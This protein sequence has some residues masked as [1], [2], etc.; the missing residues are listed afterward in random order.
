MKPLRILFPLLAIFVPP[1][2]L[3]QQSGSEV[4]EFPTVLTASRLRQPANEAPASVTVIDRE[5]IR[6][7]GARQ[8]VDLFRFV[9]GMV[10]GQRE[11]HVPTL[12]FHGFSESYFRQLQVLVDG[13]SIYS[14]L[15]G[16][17]DWGEL[18]FS[19]ED[20]ERIEIV[21]GPN[22]AAYG[23]NAFA[24]VINI[25]TRDPATEPRAAVSV[26]SGGNG[27]GDLSIRIARTGEGWRYRLSAGSR[28]DRG[29]DKLPDTTRSDF[30]NLRSHFTL[31]STDELGVNLSYVGGNTDNGKYSNNAADTNA[32]RVSHYESKSSQLRWTRA[33]GPDEEMW[34]Q[35]HHAE[36]THHEVLPYTLNLGGPL[37]FDYPISF[38]YD[39][40][41]T[42]L[43]GQQTL[44]FSERLR[45]VW[46]VQWRQDGARSKTYFHSDSWQ[47]SSLLRLFGTLE[48]RPAEKWIAH[49]GAMA[50]RNDISG[51][52][53][54]PR[55]ALVHQ[56]TPQHALRAS[57]AS[58]RRT[59]T[60]FEAYAN[61]GFDSPSGLILFL[62]L[63]LRSRPLHQSILT[64]A[65]PQ[66]ERMLSRELAYLGEFPRWRMNVDLRLF[67]DQAKDMIS[68]YSYPY[69]TVLGGLAGNTLGFRNEPK[70]NVR[71][72]AFDLRWRPWSG[73]FVAFS[74]S[75]TIVDSTN[76]FLAR[77]APVHQ[78]SLLFQQ[79][80]PFTTEFGLNY[81]RVGSMTWIGAGK[82]ETMPAYDRVDARIAKRFTWGGQKVEVAWVSR[83]VFN[84]A[85]PQFQQAYIDKRQSWLSFRLEYQ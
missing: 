77:S 43:E 19:L 44:R 30:V 57:I 58:A 4:D 56:V 49:A 32:P 21:R 40:R 71:G 39:S 36:R 53:V 11:G 51:S 66:D 29:I 31:N 45:G 85:I 47:T 1:T 72:A 37:V 52:S 34:V 50:E 74:G 65:I 15:Y 38:S 25:I 14:P 26:N 35:F 2:V 60:I 22:A 12:G 46:G 23:A 69:S 84:Q 59:P 81:H 83:N 13:V 7:S 24:G 10:V 75:R 42:D 20:V 16:G 68:Q 67:N 33:T 64:A 80:L 9:P 54:S 73:A 28:M 5:M 78:T 17:A 8:L 61:Y 3:G 70:G 62:P 76:N 63:A 55:I 27:I 79:Q 82:D 6:A 41:R 48:W 18:P